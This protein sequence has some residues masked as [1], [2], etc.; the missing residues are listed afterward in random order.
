MAGE[1]SFAVIYDR[2]TVLV[3]QLVGPSGATAT[4]AAEAPCAP[5]LVDPAVAPAAD[6]APAAGCPPPAG[7]SSSVGSV[8]SDGSDGEAEPSTAVM[9]PS[10]KRRRDHF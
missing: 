1:E 6:A 4:P 10:R 9:Q 3:A 5:D 8:T 7:P 2:L